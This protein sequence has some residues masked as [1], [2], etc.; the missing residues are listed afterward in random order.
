MSTTRK[1]SIAESLNESSRYVTHAKERAFRERQRE[2]DRV[3][4]SSPRSFA[5][6]CFAKTNCSGPSRRTDVAFVS[7]FSAIIA[8]TAV[9]S[10][11]DATDRF[12]C[13]FS[14]L[15]QSHHGRGKIWELFTGG[16]GEMQRTTSGIVRRAAKRASRRESSSYRAGITIPDFE[17]RSWRA[18]NMGRRTADDDDGYVPRFRL[19]PLLFSTRTRWLYPVGRK[20][21]HPLSSSGCAAHKRRM[22]STKCGGNS[23]F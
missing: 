4:G 10:H 9:G 3:A 23:Y 21:R 20:I 1:A 13:S 17:P 22:F 16:V 7:S 19:A 5:M 14:L 2:N 15:L 8:V 12:N 6:L 11:Q 18:I